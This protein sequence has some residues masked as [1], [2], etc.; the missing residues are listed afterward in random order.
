METKELSTQH[1]AAALAN[2]LRVRIAAGGVARRT[3]HTVGSG[4]DTAAGA[5][6]DAGSHAVLYVRGFVAGLLR[7]PN[8]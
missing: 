2:I 3:M 5:V 6:T 8:A 1:G 7:V 4:V